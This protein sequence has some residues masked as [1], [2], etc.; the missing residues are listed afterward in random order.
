MPTPT[1]LANL[2]RC[3]HRVYLDVAGD[4]AE[5]LAASS[6]LELLWESGLLHEDRIIACLGAVDA[7]VSDDK[8][9]RIAETRR[10]MAAGT[11]LIY[12]GYFEVGDLRGE[13]DLLEKVEHPSALGAFAYIPVDI[14]ASSVWEKRAIPTP[15]EKFLLQLS[16]YAELLEDAH[17][18][19]PDTGK[20]IDADG[21]ENVLDLASYRV[22]YEEQRRRL[23]RIRGGTETT[24]PGWK[25]ECANCQWQAVCVRALEEVDDVTL[26][27]GVG[28]SYRAKLAT[29][30]VRSAAD[31]AGAEP[32]A[33][34]QVKGI[35]DARSTAWVR[36][37]K[38]Q[39]RGTPEI[40]DAWVP[41]DVA[42][43]V[44]YDI[45]DFTPDPYLY[46]HGLLIR[47]RGARHFGEAGFTERDWGTFEPLCSSLPA[48][49]EEDLWRRFLAKV[50]DLERRGTYAVYVYSHHEQTT[51]EKLSQK[52]G[53]SLDLDHFIGRFV[54]LLPVVRRCVVFP[55]DATGLKTL[56]R[57]I[58]FEWRDE[59]PGGSQS[60][61][62]WAEYIADPVGNAS[63]R[64]RVIAYN[65]DD[66]RATFALRDWL[67][68][69]AH[70]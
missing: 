57:Y 6:F 62:W 59:D 18:W 60:M 70:T 39:K 19:R 22:T 8:A 54:D 3:A 21:E 47:D 38:A 56:A 36:Q 10:L 16:A 61:A 55:T 24:V 14:K 53:G 69:H 13:P 51:L 37:A 31:L 41:P 20:I 12:H 27:A 49:S 32:F 63:Q 30:G 40:L 34:T 46:L 35:G 67:E 50:A 29:V 52:Y 17:G 58:G 25:S 2:A 26:V 44:S 42:F 66:V 23:A 15:K 48:D 5:K 45:E 1:D 68:R 43:E 9:A 65:E 64:D 7:K 11:A 33:L 4:P 28:E